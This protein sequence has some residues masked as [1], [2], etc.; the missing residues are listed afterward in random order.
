[1][2]TSLFPN[3]D[4]IPSH[5]LVLL[6]PYDTVA[7]QIKDRAR[8]RKHLKWNEEKEEYNKAVYNQY[9]KHLN[10]SGIVKIKDTDLDAKFAIAEKYIYDIMRTFS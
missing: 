4:Y 3:S 1:M 9:D 2:I 5:V 6:P 7:F 8:K 10:V